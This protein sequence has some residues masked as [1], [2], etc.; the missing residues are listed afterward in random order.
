MFLGLYHADVCQ[1]KTNDTVSVLQFVHD[2]VIV[3][4]DDTTPSFQLFSGSEI[5]QVNTSLGETVSVH[6]LCSQSPPT[7]YC[8]SL[9]RHHMLGLFPRDRLANKTLQMLSWS[10]D[11]TGS[12]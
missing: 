2:E 11:K 10:Q 9:T 5:W 7:V 8:K 1:A 6:M 4:E 12:D 3:V